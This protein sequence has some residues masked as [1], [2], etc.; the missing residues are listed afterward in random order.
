MVDLAAWQQQRRPKSELEEWQ[1]QLAANRR[2]LDALEV[3]VRYMLEKRRSRRGATDKALLRVVLE[4]LFGMMD[5]GR[6]WTP[7]VIA[8]AGRLDVEGFRTL[9]QDASALACSRPPVAS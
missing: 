9:V 6:G 7:I 4:E 3:S 5:H 8:A 1:E 2:E